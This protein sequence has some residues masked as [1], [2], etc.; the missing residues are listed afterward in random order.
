MECYLLSGPKVRSYRK[1]MLG[2][3]LNKGKFWV[4][5]QKLVDQANTIC[6]N[7]QMTE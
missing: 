1:Y 3:W 5:E 7:S 6:K 4:S 2:L